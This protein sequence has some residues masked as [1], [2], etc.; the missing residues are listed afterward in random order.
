MKTKF[1]KASFH[2]NRMVLATRN[3]IYCSNTDD[4]T[5]SAPLTDNDKMVV[6]TSGANHHQIVFD[7]A[8]DAKN[9]VDEISLRLL[10]KSA[11]LQ[12]GYLVSRTLKLLLA[13]ALIMLVL[14][15][16]ASSF[17]LT[18]A[19]LGDDVS[20]GNSRMSIPAT[21][22]E[23]PV[24]GGVNF[25]EPVNQGNLSLG[26]SSPKAS[27]STASPE[28]IARTLKRGV[29]TGD[30]SVDLGKGNGQDIYVFA[31]P[32]CPHCREAESVFENLAKEGMNIHVFPVSV[33]SEGFISSQ[34]DLYRKTL[35]D[36]KSMLCSRDDKR[37]AQWLSMMTQTPSLTSS[38]THPSDE[39][40]A[41]NTALTTNNAMYHAL[42]LEGTPAI[43]S[44]TGE[45]F[46]AEQT[47]TVPAVK[48]WVEDK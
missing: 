16:N 24:S 29:I 20:L 11:L 4:L 35:K 14:N 13:V 25:A 10:R 18:Q 19:L 46:P 37:T 6:L 40:A 22:S 15:L 5:V 41:G 7:N 33:I 26:G 38:V 27:A 12:L 23:I 39:C 17:R 8:A 32:L 43:I 1:F 31:D 36:V 30:Y 28:I 34:P 44:A 3:A 47:L 42:A 45:I 48:K 21:L 9:F 2:R